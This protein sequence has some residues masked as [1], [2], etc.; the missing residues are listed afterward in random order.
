M[1][2]TKEEDSY[3]DTLERMDAIAI[4]VGSVDVKTLAYDY[5]NSHGAYDAAECDMFCDDQ[6]DFFID[7]LFTAGR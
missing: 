6:M 5:N 3:L 7:R 1:S 2:I 4:K